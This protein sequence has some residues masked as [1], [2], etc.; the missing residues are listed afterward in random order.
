MGILGVSS[1]DHSSYG[2]HVCLA[3]GGE[4]LSIIARSAL[5]DTFLKAETT[6]TRLS[7]F[8]SRVPKWVVVKI[9][10]PFWVP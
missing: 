2:L 4:G 7:G 6:L 8:S 9:M 10:L 1:L 3:H 5:A